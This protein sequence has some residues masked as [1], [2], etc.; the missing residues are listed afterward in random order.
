MRS[1][2]GGDGIHRYATIS[3]LPKSRLS[4]VS[5]KGGLQPETSGKKILV[6]QTAV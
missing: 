1:S 4:I 6:L 2:E 3:I 5:G